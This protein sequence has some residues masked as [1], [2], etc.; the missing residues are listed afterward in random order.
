M[1]AEQ[2]VIPLLVS[3]CAHFLYLHVCSWFLLHAPAIHF[4]IWLFIA[5]IRKSEGV[6]VIIFMIITVY[7]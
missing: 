5:L 4:R 3:L 2:C 7:A 6:R 1:P